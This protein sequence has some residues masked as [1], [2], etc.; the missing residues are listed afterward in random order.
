M[1]H[2]N[3]RLACLKLAFELGGSIDEVIANAA[4]LYAFTLEGVS[5]ASRS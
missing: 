4:K 1:D 3:I 5:P 2:D